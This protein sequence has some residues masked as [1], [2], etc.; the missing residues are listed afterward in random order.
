MIATYAICGF[1]NPASIGIMVSAL[2]ELM[3]NKRDKV[4]KVIFRAFIAGA[5]VC[6]M[7]ACYAAILYPTEMIGV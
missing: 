4:N 2:G 6:L 7:T 5:V 3:P 1:S